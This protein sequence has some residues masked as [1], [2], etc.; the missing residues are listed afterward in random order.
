[1]SGSSVTYGSVLPE[2]DLTT[3]AET[4]DLASSLVLH[5]AA[6]PSTW[7]FPL[8]LSGLTAAIASD[9]GV[10]LIGASGQVVG[11]IGHGFAA[12]SSIAPHSA[13]PAET[14]AVTYQII[15]YNGGQALEASLDAS[16]LADPARV[17][18]VK[19]TGFG[20]ITTAPAGTTAPGGT[21]SAVSANQIRSAA[22]AAAVSCTNNGTSYCAHPDSGGTYV[23][24]PYTND[25]HTDTVL[26]IG[27]DGVSNQYAESYLQFS[28]IGTALP[29]ANITAASLNLFDI[30]A[31]YCGA[32][33]PFSVYR[34]S[35]SWSLT[36][37]KDW[38]QRPSQ[39][40]DALGTFNSKAPSAACTNTSLTPTT[41]GWMSVSLA[42]WLFNAWTL[43]NTSTWPDDGLAIAAS[44]ALADDYQ[45]KKFDSDNASANIPYLELTYAA[46]VAPQISTVYPQNDY[47]ATSLTPELQATGSDS[48]SWPDTLGYYFAVY[49]SSGTLVANST[50]SSTQGSKPGA[51]PTCDQSHYTT[52][53]LTDPDWTVP[54]NE[55]TWGQVYYWQA[56]DCDGLEE[57]ASPPTY[58]TTQVP[59]PTVGQAGQ[60]GG[61]QGISP[62]SSD[63]TSSVTDAQVSSV[64][65]SLSIERD[66]DSGDLSSA[67]AFGAG[68]SS[69]LDMKVTNGLTDAAGNVDTVDVTY[70]DGSQ[71]GFGKNYNGSFSAPQGRYATLTAVTGGYTLVDKNDTKYSFLQALASGGY[72][73]SSITD[74]LG[75]VLT[76]AY[77][78]GQIS[79]MASSASGRTLGIVWATPTGATYSHVQKVFTNPVSGTDQN[80]DLSWVYSYTGD[81]LTQVCPPISGSQC[82]K[83]SYTAGTDFPSAVMD[84]G[85]HSYWR[86]DEAVGAT[87][88][89]SSVLANEQTDQATYANVTLGQPGP[90]L[91]STAT[92]AGFNGTSS[93]VTLPTKLVDSANYQSVSVWFKTS[94][95]GGVILGS[96]KDPITD[97]STTG[98]YTPNLYVGTDGLLHGMFW[99]ATTTPLNSKTT[100]DDGKWHLAVLTCAGTTETLYVDN[101]TPVTVT[102]VTVSNSIVDGQVE[103]L[104]N[105][106]LGAGFIGGNWPN[107]SHSGGNGIPEYFNGPISDAGFWDRP[108]TGAEVS[109][110]YQA[111]STQA[112]QV[113]TITRPSGSVYAQV[114]YSTVTGAVSQLTGDTDGVWKVAA[115]TVTGSSQAY[116]SSV[117]GQE[118]ADYWRLADTNTTTAVNQINSGTATYN[119]VNQGQPGP[120]TDSNSDSF[121]GTSSYLS[122]PSGLVTGAGNQSVSL[123]FN[124]KTAGGVIFASSAS[125]LSSGTTTSSYV[126]EIYVDTGGKL[127]AEFWNGSATPVTSSGKVDDG[128]WHNVVLTAGT[129]GTNSQA[130]YLDGTLVGSLSGTISGAGETNVYLGTGFIGNGWPNEPHSGN[131]TASPWYF[132]GS[133]SDVAF[134]NSHLSAAQVQQEWAA[135]QSSGGLVPV[136]T[137]TITDPGG[138]TLSYQMDPL[139][140]DRIVAQ[141]DALVKTTKFGYN[142]AGFQDSVT[143]PDGNV[144][145]TGFDVRGNVVSQTTCQNLAAQN[146]STEYATYYPDDTSTSLTPDPRNDLVLTDAGPGSASGTDKTYLTT[147]AYNTLGE[148]T[149]QTGP[150]VPGFP[151][152]R[153]TAY[154][155]TASAPATLTPGYNSAGE[156][157]GTAPS[158]LPLTETSPGGAQTSYEYYSDGD[159]YQVTNPDGTRTTYAYDGLGRETAKTVYSSTYPSGLVTSYTYDQMGNV[160]T[161][162]DPT[163]TDTVGSPHTAVISTSYDADGDVLSQTVS[164][165]TGGDTSRQVSDSYNGYDQMISSTDANTN[166]THYTYDAYG[167]L[168]TETDPAGNITDYT[169]DA[170]GD[171][172]TA[173]LVNYKGTATGSCQ[174]VSGGLVESSRT[175]DPAGQLAAITNADCDTTAYT[176]TGNG[177]LSTVTRCSAWTGTACGGSTYVQEAN[178][179]N[180]AGQ[181]ITRVTSN[182]QTTTNL[183][184]DAADQTTAITLDPA[185]LDR[186][187]SYVYSPDDAV[188]QQTITG[189]RVRCPGQPD[190]L[191]LRPDGQRDIAERQQ[192]H[193]Q[194]AGADRVVAA[195]GAELGLRF[196]CDRRV[197]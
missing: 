101:Q 130:V 91:G 186:T 157:S 71:V 195:D 120:F 81:E 31:F 76:F 62:G 113:S 105:D 158:G 66:Y 117:L 165:S 104:N 100:V 171:L 149:S 4:E 21:V 32:A 181:L 41:G 163:V 183:T 84:T 109:G 116:V 64:G 110:L 132:T 126:P 63:Y 166:T 103:T 15:S 12:D 196:G 74:A 59:Q 131:T 127:E 115:P 92:A 141:T 151:N 48:D 155:Y 114:S 107:E 147:N 73:I 192:C 57:G 179:F 170:D 80:T 45:W 29:D 112:E 191:H 53:W 98:Y 111:G 28:Q 16:W 160:L 10:D 123:W 82:T 19:I 75:N 128:N 70:P 139:N 194:L 125:A 138:K 39:G 47:N 143:D 61:A 145:L 34:I 20:D 161:E 95:A 188:V 60:N 72:G 35:S 134:Y 65:P 106:Y 94:T 22:A 56:V 6:A 7:V 85:P 159:V 55:L 172:L 93:Y 13:E 169:Y 43:G 162:A 89:A 86:L 148:L 11:V 3:N 33:E 156:Q 146:C 140:G 88:A 36:G 5:S 108:L 25:Y 77:T 9:G 154:T 37:N 68:W 30:W 144:T 8:T 78:S 50:M 167:N 182:G 184:P 52:G 185:G 58:M 180:A 38:A 122:L 121:N 27:N 87:K 173:T 152:G 102:G 99:D 177:L 119:A 136:E 26:K 176:Y 1:M 142:T 153:T 23:M 96:S 174:T 40:A 67:G 129:A 193:Q 17:F 178:S 168:A 51:V 90:L 135:S 187:T 189:S 54:E 175:Y 150:P 164:D 190:R 14:D 137:Q 79:Q 18:P 24:N 83:Y 197:R 124:T 2:T 69:I 97:S 44:T 118:P 42:T 46:D 133:I 49:N